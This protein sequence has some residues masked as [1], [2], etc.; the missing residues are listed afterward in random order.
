MRGRSHGGEG[1]RGSVLSLLG[2]GRGQVPQGEESGC[3]CGGGGVQLYPVS[4]KSLL[5]TII[6]EVNLFSGVYTKFIFIITEI[7]RN[8]SALSI[9]YFH[10]LIKRTLSL[11]RFKL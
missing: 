4:L 11:F 1:E 6:L 3:V 8:H 9:I 2:G 10:N 7:V 5:E